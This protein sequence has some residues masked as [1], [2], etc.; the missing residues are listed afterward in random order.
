MLRHYHI[1]DCSSCILTFAVEQA[2]EEQ[3]AIVC[4]V[5][6]SGEHIDDVGSGEMVETHN[7]VDDDN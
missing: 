3:D 1:Y 5:C 2:F 4:P 6:T 7:L